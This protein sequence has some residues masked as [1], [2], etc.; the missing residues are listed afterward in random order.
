MEYYDIVGVILQ[1][2]HENVIFGGTNLRHDGRRITGRLEDIYGESSIR[3]SLSLSQREMSF[4]KIYEGSEEIVE[5]QFKKIGDL[6]VGT[7]R[8]GGALQ[9]ESLCE[10]ISPRGNLINNW[11]DIRSS[12]ELS[13]ETLGIIA[14]DVL[15]RMEKRGLIALSGDGESF[16]V[17]PKG[18]SN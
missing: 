8:W 6:W 5:Y 18:S 3:G 16:F 12:A 1:P 13:D 11:T 17:M 10:L 7:Y 4:R 2:F 15:E 14:N 9:G